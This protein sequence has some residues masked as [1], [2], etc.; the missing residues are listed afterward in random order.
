[1]IGNY[2]LKNKEQFKQT[3]ELM[4]E[5]TYKYANIRI[6]LVVKGVK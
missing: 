1:M 6:V 2:Y 5:P 4:F 3:K